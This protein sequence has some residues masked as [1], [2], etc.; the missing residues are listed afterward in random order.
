MMRRSSHKP[1]EVRRGIRTH[2]SPE[3]GGMM[4][5]IS[6]PSDKGRLYEVQDFVRDC[7]RGS[8]A[9]QFAQ[10]QVE[11]VVEEVFVNIADHAYD[12]R[13]DGE[14]RVCC[15]MDNLNH[16]LLIAFADRGDRFDPLEHRD[17]DVSKGP[18][19]RPPGGLGIFLVKRNVDLVRYRRVRG[20][21]VLAMLKR[22]PQRGDITNYR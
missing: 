21:N 4:R 20:W 5:I 22:I 12:G 19:G 2:A 13:A 1:Y 3:E 10:A 16:V 7:M 6:I 15:S 11:L 9:N 14:V 18:R 8:G 17:P